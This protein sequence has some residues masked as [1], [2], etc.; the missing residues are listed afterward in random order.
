MKTLTARRSICMEWD[1]EP[2]GRGCVP[3]VEKHATP[4]VASIK[5]GKTV[6]LEEIISAVRRRLNGLLA[7]FDRYFL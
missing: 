1:V 6:D 5:A 4:H 3:L 7:D 2:V